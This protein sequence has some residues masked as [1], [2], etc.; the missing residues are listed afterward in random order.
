MLQGHVQ[1]FLVARG[2][3]QCHLLAALLPA[4]PLGV[5]AWFLMLMHVI[6]D[7]TAWKLWQSCVPIQTACQCSHNPELTVRETLDFSA[8]CQGMKARLGEAQLARLRVW[9]CCSMS[10]STDMARSQTVA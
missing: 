7:P 8:R 5:K 3:M 6:L 10:F 9:L 2:N 1:D 4:M